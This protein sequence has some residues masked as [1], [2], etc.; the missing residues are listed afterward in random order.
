MIN[1]IQKNTSG[2]VIKAVITLVFTALAWTETPARPIN[3]QQ[4]FQQATQFMQQHG[5]VRPLKAVAAAYPKSMRLNSPGSHSDDGKPYYV[6]DRGQQEGFI[7]VA[8]DDEVAETILGYCD[9]GTFNYDELPPNMRE[10]LDGYAKEI[11]DFESN[12]VNKANKVQRIPTHPKVAPLITSKWSQGDPYNQECPM[13]FTLGRSV[14]GCVATAYAQILYYHRSKMVT[15]TQ[16]AMPAYDTWTEHATYGRLHVEG[17]PAGSPIDWD[18]MTDSYGS[19]S[20]GLQKKAVAQL[21]HYCGVAVNMDYTNSSSGAQS[22]AVYDALRNYFGFGNSV[23]YVYGKSNE[24]WDQIIYN[25]VANQRPVYISGAD[26]SMGHAFVCDGY[27]GDHR[28]HINWGWGGQSD[29]HYYLTNLTPG[30][31][32]IGGS[33]DGYTNGR[34]CII[35]I[36]PE[37]YQE[38]TMPFTDATARRLCTAAWDQNGDGVLSYGEAAA[39][40]DLGTVLK[41][42]NIKS[43]AELHYFTSLE[44]IAD[45]AF[46]GCQQLTTILLPRQLK[47]IGARAFKDCK[48]IADISLPSSLQTIGEEAFS[49]CTLLRIN[50][51]PDMLKAVETGTFRNCTSLTEMTLPTTLTRIGSE[52]FY[53]CTKLNEMTVNTLLPQNLSMGTDVF[54]NCAVNTATLHIQQGTRAYFEGDAQWS[55]FGTIKEHRNLASATFT[56]MSPNTQV[57]LYHV[58][59]G[60]FL[61]KGEAWGTQAVVGSSTP[62][63][64]KLVHGATMPEG[65]YALYSDDTGASDRHYTFRTDDDGNVGKGVKAAFVDGNLEKSG[66]WLVTDIGN[67]TYTFSVPSGYEGYDAACCWGVQTDHQSQYVQPTWGVYSDIV[68]EGHEQDCQWRFALYDADRA[69]TYETAA[70]LEN[71]IIMAKAKHVACQEEEAVFDNMQ[72]TVEEMRQAQR[73]LRKKMGL[74]DFA[75]DQVALMCRLNFDLDGDRELSYVEASKTVSL[76]Y[77]FYGMAI[78]S[79][80]EMQYFTSIKNIDGASFSDCTSLTSIILPNSIERIYYYAFRNCTKLTSINLPEY[81][82][83][84]GNEAF[85]N[86]KQLKTVRIDNPDP[87]SIDIKTDA[88]SGVSL[89]RCTLQVPVGSKE[90]YA[91]APVWR[92]FGTIEEVRTATRPRTSSVYEGARGYIMNVATRKMITVG[93]A[94]GTQAVVDR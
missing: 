23:K 59:S 75:D 70:V 90:L 32:G 66:H 71:L 58:G 16:A 84:I 80:D 79:F 51:L 35:G 85:A 86:C 18:N 5:T 15:E 24:E 30:D 93:E 50:E 41:G 45:E 89:K 34:E 8:G 52:A 39:V 14:T 44:V 25:E 28:F 43:F 42:Q 37:N 9:H 53:G 38:R 83:T 33:G 56:A 60:R 78:T 22:S 94:Y 65:V 55:L 48:K 57:Y 63:R 82:A 31:Q 64:F 91:A 19:N 17:I 88:F 46:S 7:I 73:T 20:T 13:Y 12:N 2:T 4:A 21:M 10:W 47:H 76:R 77:V 6:F 40:T 69:A 27:D 54:A 92:N 36:E 67:D 81:I 11:E 62:M 1:L 87:Q 29:G 26:G 3:R 68:Y 49:G 61:S 72:S 74:M